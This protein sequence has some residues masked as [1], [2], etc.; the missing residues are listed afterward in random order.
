MATY[1]AEIE[2]I[3]QKYNSGEY[4]IDE[5]NEKLDGLDGSVDGNYGVGFHLDENK[6]KDCNAWMDCGVGNCE[7]IKVVNGKVVKPTGMHP[8][9]RI[10]YN[11]ET[12]HVGDDKVTLIKGAPTPDEVKR[13]PLPDLQECMK[14]DKSLAG[15][16]QRVST[17]QGIFD[18]YHDN[19]GY[20]TKAAR[21]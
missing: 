10:Y 16:V 18:V 13:D 12:W 3:L 15:K 2:E 5:A 1:R 6:G 9:Y 8:T 20:A 17:K 19:L 7:P 21:V 14:R 4:T 11:G